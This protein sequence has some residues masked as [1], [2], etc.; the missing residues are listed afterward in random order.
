MP[1]QDLMRAHQIDVEIDLMRGESTIDSPRHGDD[2]GGG[3]E[4][5]Q[6]RSTPPGVGR[7]L[8]FVKNAPMFLIAPTDVARAHDLRLERDDLV[9]LPTP[10]ESGERPPPWGADRTEM[11]STASQGPP[12]RR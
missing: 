7:T 2:K 12:R 4:G 6:D 5:P 9:T 1:G 10:D 8:A 3:A 11:Q